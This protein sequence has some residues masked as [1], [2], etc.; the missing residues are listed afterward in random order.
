MDEMLRSALKVSEVHRGRYFDMDNDFTSGRGGR[1][2]LVCI[3]DY[4]TYANGEERLY[5]HRIDF[6]DNECTGTSSVFGYEHINPDAMSVGSNG[7]RCMYANRDN[8]EECFR[9]NGERCTEEN[10]LYFNTPGFSHRTG[11]GGRETHV[12]WIFPGKIPPVPPSVRL[13][14]DDNAVDIYWDD[15]SEFDLDPDTGQRDFESYRV[16][17]VSNWSRPAG[18]SQASGPGALE[19]ALISEIDLIN[20]IPAGIG[21]S[22]SVLGLGQ[23]T[24]LE[25][26]LYIPVSLSDPQFEGLAEVMQTFVD[27]DINNRLFKMPT[28]RNSLSAVRPGMAPFLPWEY[29]P[30]V[31]DTFFAITA[32]AAAPPPNRV[33]PKRAANFYHY[34]DQDVHNGFV[35][36]YS[37]VATD[38]EL[39]WDG[40]RYQVAGVGIQSDPENNQH[41]TTPAPQAQTVAQR[42]Q[43][44]VNIYVYPNPATREALAEFQQQPPSNSSPTGVR[45][46]FNNLPAAQN[47]VTVY[48]AS[49]DMVNTLYHDGTD[50][51]GAVS[52]DLMSRNGQEVVSGIYL[53]T[54]ESND[55]HFQ[56]FRGRFVVVR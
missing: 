32:R 34:R 36:F 40:S 16:W 53:Y 22:Q 39:V 56:T 33:I 38:H 12:P 20:S 25:G 11:N 44:G 18:T 23:N 28:I 5:N 14:A 30:A 10:G 8:C 52:W 47:R 43:E 41:L 50:G 51:T 24:G 55:D 31:L 42:A 48:T 4:P 54:V 49:G 7:R 9:A 35:T 27:T 29:A 3:G 19:W 2:S 13:V 21:G 37:V 6:M 46:M 15:R 17:R 26:S 1:E 45:V